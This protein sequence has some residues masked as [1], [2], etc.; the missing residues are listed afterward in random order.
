MPMRPSTN[1]QVQYTG[2]RA[3]G[4][5]LSAAGTAADDVK[6]EVY[7]RSRFYKRG[8]ARLQRG[9]QLEYP[10]GRNCL[11]DNRLMY[12]ALGLT[13]RDHRGPR[14]GPSQWVV[15]GDRVLKNL[16]T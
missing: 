6:E 16:R 13:Q 1:S 9:R 11:H 4:R 10:A 12:H 14:L 3:I 2:N 8:F 15:D 5:V 7:F